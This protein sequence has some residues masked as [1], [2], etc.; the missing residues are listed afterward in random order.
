MQ[1][2]GAQ[3]PKQVHAQQQCFGARQ[4]S[5][6][7]TAAVGADKFGACQLGGG[8]LGFEAVKTVNRL[9]QRNRQEFGG[10]GGVGFGKRVQLNGHDMLFLR[11]CGRFACGLLQ[12]GGIP[13][14]QPQ[15]GN[16][17]QAA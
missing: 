2:L 14:R 13:I 10:A 17:F 1:T 7:G 15:H 12:R 5:L 11:P 6:N 9:A 8:G 3:L 16:A 4:G